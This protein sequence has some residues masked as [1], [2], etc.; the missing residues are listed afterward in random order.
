MDTEPTQETSLARGDYLG[1][2]ADELGQK[3]AGD[4]IAAGIRQKALFHRRG[5]VTL[6]RDRLVLGAWGDAGDL[7]LR[8]EDIASVRR[9]YTELYG[10][11][12]GAL[13]NS[14]TPLILGT[15]T[16]GEIYLLIERK[17]FRETTHSR[18]WEKRL[19]DWLA[20]AR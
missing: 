16:A 7:E 15:A 10:R 5:P 18:T 12:I 8:P 11:F 4:K 19:K 17:D 1:A 3:T 13:L 20:T 9:A 2:T 14:G 6:E